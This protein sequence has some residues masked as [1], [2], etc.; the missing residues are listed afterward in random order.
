MNK[1]TL[2]FSAILRADNPRTKK[3]DAI[4]SAVIDRVLSILIVPVSRECGAMITRLDDQ[5]PAFFDGIKIIFARVGDF[6]FS[7]VLLSG[8]SS[9]YFV[10]FSPSLS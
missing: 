3:D 1:D 4:D 8:S 9:S 5:M 10:S 2:L 7:L 6:C